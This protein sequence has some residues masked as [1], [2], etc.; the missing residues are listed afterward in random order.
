VL[1]QFEYSATGEFLGY[2][3]S[4]IFFDK[5]SSAYRM[6]KNGNAGHYELPLVNAKGDS[7][8][9]Y[10]P[11]NVK[12]T[13][14]LV[15]G[16]N[17]PDIYIYN[18]ENIRID[19]QKLKNLSATAIEALLIGEG[20]IKGMDFSGNVYPVALN[21]KGPQFYDLSRGIPGEY[22]FQY[23][24]SCVAGHTYKKITFTVY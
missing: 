10:L 24:L 6:L 13:D 14:T 9:E 15:A 12:D 1:Y 3:E 18:E 21:F 11:V 19:G 4:K 22:T 23:D 17:Y 5:E 7:I 16:Q 20:N 8:G 2:G